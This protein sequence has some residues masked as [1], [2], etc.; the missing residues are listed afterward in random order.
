MLNRLRRFVN[1]LRAMFHLRELELRGLRTGKD[2]YLGAGV[3][4]DP[5]FCWLVELGD[6]T[7]LAPGVRVLAHDA[8]TKRYLGYSRV[9]R[10]TI[11]RRVFVGADSVILPGVTI[12]DNAIVGAGSVVRHDVPA[13][14]V[15]AGNPAAVVSTTEHYIEG[16]RREMR[17]RPAFDRDGYTVAG[18]VT[19]ENRERMREQLRDGG[20]YVH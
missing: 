15:V 5:D 7:T 11:G 8:S 19:P 20:G 14:T 6:E 16:H 1:R 18:G 12:G 4:I 17:E 3:T 13:A 9:A 10:V 2:V